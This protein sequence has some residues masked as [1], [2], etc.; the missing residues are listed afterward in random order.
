MRFFQSERRLSRELSRML[1]APQDK[2]KNVEMR[3][4]KDEEDFIVYLPS[5]L[6][7]DEVSYHHYQIRDGYEVVL[8]L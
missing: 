8:R 1:T 4:Q 5:D 2:M 7:V 3:A 6:E